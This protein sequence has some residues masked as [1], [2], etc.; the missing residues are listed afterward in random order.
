[1]EFTEK[2][3]GA[4][5]APISSGDDD[6]LGFQF[7]VDALHDFMLA[8]ETPM[9]VAIQGD[10]GS[11]KTSLMNL[12]RARIGEGS[13]GRVK[14][15]WIN[16]W[17][18][19]QFDLGAD[20]PFSVIS[21]F[22]RQLSRDEGVL[23]SIRR[24]LSEIS[25]RRA[26]GKA[27]AGAAML[28]TAFVAGKD[29]AE[30][31]SNTM[32]GTHF[33]LTERIIEMRA[34]L[35][36]LVQRTRR[37][38]GIDR[39]V[40]FIDDIDRLVPER[41]VELLEV[42]KIFLD[43]P[44]C[45][46]VLA[47]DYQVVSRG[48]RSKFG[49]DGRDLK[50]KN[51]FDK[52]I[53]LPFSM[54][55]GQ[56]EVSTYLHNRL[57]ACGVLLPHEDDAEISL[58][59][60]LLAHSVGFNPRGLKRLTN[61]L[62]VLRL[63]AQGKG[64]LAGTTTEG[65]RADRER[66]LFAALCM[67]TAFEPLYVALMDIACWKGVDLLAAFDMLQSGKEISNPDAE[68]RPLVARLKAAVVECEA[69]RPGASQDI[70]S[71][72]RAVNRAIQ[73]ENGTSEGLDPEEIA[74]FI[75]MLRFSSIT[76]TSAFTQE[77]SMRA[78]LSVAHAAIAHIKDEVG[79]ELGLRTTLYEGAE[80]VWAAPIIRD[81]GFLPWMGFDRDGALCLSVDISTYDKSKL[82]AARARAREW[83]CEF[84]SKLVPPERLITKRMHATYGVVFAQ[85]APSGLAARSAEEIQ[86]LVQ[87]QYDLVWLP[88]IRDLL[89][90]R[91]LG[92]S[93]FDELPSLA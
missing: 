88:L 75:S 83:C 10:W 13:G 12:V 45:V 64:V 40:I 65:T 59:E 55:V 22:S 31:L 3:H 19:S 62:Q 61:C 78:D 48:L 16:T 89:R 84:L 54:P 1:M 37:D 35:D 17:Q 70:P 34:N 30:A 2:C 86:I 49:A 80:G 33:D 23:S 90:R 18:F 7:Y 25:M 85:L 53:Q 69:E 76:A 51:F 46:F 82:Q 9:T 4:N 77:Q 11:G 72:V 67:Q 63:V 32:A 52:I 15:V 92:R 20:L 71:F 28:T 57:A 60:G 44:G 74:M 73:I 36:S 66:A 91:D 68:S 81:L 42:M 41:A 50:G 14:C 5:D 38:H 47:C 87:D 79:K 27:A 29:T 8:C 24:T 58:Y 43:L 56:L 26:A 39:I 6:T 93:S 21:L